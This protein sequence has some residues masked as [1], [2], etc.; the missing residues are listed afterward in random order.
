MMSLQQV[1]DHYQRL[2]GLYELTLGERLLYADSRRTAIEG[3]RLT[4]GTTVVD[5]ACG[6]GLNFPLLQQRIGPSGHLIGIDLTDRMLARAR[7]R[8]AKAGWAN[9]TLVHGD[10][11]TM[12]RERLVADGALSV[13]VR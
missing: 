10:I 2:A 5:V 9:V 4:P 12:A 7:R 1:Q 3:L 6:T 8:V 11:Q 13:N